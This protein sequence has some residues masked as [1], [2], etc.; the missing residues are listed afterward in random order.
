MCSIRTTP[1]WDY[2]IIVAMAATLSPGNEQRDYFG[3]EAADRV[4][5]LGRHQEPGVDALT[6]RIIYAKS[7]ANWRRVQGQG[8]LLLWNNYVAQPTMARTAPHAGTARPP[9][10]LPKYQFGR[11]PPCGGG[12]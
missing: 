4:G 11:F 8:P 9:H 1:T 3:S 2:D 5:Q 7:C 6:E 10:P 12:C